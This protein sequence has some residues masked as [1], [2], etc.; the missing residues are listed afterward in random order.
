VIG[1]GLYILPINLWSLLEKSN[2]LLIGALISSALTS[3]NIIR[4]VIDLI[5]I[6]INIEDPLFVPKRG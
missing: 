1:I 5:N 4:K 3:V 2:F 6:N